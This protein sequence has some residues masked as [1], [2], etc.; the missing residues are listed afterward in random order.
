[1]KPLDD[2]S[3]T[4][5]N[6]E[7]G[8][9]WTLRLSKKYVLTGAIFFVLCSCVVLVVVAGV[10]RQHDAQPQNDAK[11]L[12]T[13]WN[14]HDEDGEEEDDDRED[15][16]RYGGGH[17][18]WRDREGKYRNGAVASESPLCSTMGAE[19]MENGGNSIDGAVMTDLC[20]GIVHCFATGAGGGGVMLIL[21]EDGKAEVLDYRETA[22]GLSTA[23]MYVVNEWSSTVGP[24]AAGVPGSL[25]G[26]KAV[27]DRYGTTSWESLLLAASDLAASFPVDSLLASRLQSSEEAVLSDPGFAGVFAPNGVLLQEGETCHWTSLSETYATIAQDGLEALYGG[28]V[29]EKLIEDMIAKDP[30]SIMTLADLEG[31]EP[32]WRDP[33]ESTYKGDKVYGAPPPFT[34]GVIN[35]QA[36]NILETISLRRT[37]RS[38]HYW[39]QSLLFGYSDRTGLGDPASAYNIEN[40]MSTYI[41]P[42]MTKKCHAADLRDRISPTQTFPVEYYE[43]LVPLQA[44]VEDHGT[45][46]FSVYQKR[47][48]SV[49]LTSTVNFAFGSKFMSPQTGI[50]LNN[51]MDDFSTPGAS[52][53]YGYPPSESNFPA[54]GLRPASSMSPSIIATTKRDKTIPRLIYGGGG[55]SMI[56]SGTLSVALRHLEL[57]FKLQDAINTPRLHVQLLPDFVFW[58]PD[59]P[60]QNRDRLVEYGYNFYPFPFGGAVVQ[61]ISFNGYTITAASD[62]RKNG[63]PAGY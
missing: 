56:I 5:F 39:I 50:I 41:V 4:D 60:E 27:H 28:E 46:H 24:L 48:K 9:H 51:E 49:A 1:M 32:V 36:L 40:N 43:D 29:G 54:P 23:D 19:I 62:K 47:G 6:E 30:E 2:E 20:L 58:E 59:Y 13:T 22:P 34:G 25:R 33:I 21:H 11:D 55:G 42:T 31:Y 3:G 52:N 8:T 14:D 7:A 35:A 53:A 12:S 45:S 26:L 44:V 57:G 10:G 63:K 18:G 37:V 15:D 38:E 16:D 61:A 17:G